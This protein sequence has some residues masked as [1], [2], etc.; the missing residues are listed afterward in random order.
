MRSRRR[1][2]SLIS[3]SDGA[4]VESDS[5]N[6]PAPKKRKKCTKVLKRTRRI[7]ENSAS[8][9]DKET[10]NQSDLDLNS[11]GLSDEQESE[12]EVSDFSSSEDSSD[13]W[14]P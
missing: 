7:N 10:T 2:K 12:W 14:I 6:P 4:D 8:N 13:E 3:E 1:N 9:E 11:T 5:E